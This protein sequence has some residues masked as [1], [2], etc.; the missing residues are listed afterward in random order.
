MRNIYDVLSQIDFEKHCEQY[1]LGFQRDTDTPT[2]SKFRQESMKQFCFSLI[3][4]FYE[5]VLQDHLQQITAV[6]SK[7]RRTRKA[8]DVAVDW[9]KKIKERAELQRPKNG[10][11]PTYYASKVLQFSQMVDISIDQINTITEQKDVK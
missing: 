7:L 2:M 3:Q 6:D 1:A 8:L 5:I 9:L 4:K 10:L 11:S